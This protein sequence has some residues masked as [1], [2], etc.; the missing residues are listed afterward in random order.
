MCE[1]V[2]VGFG[3]SL[4][5]VRDFLQVFLEFLQ[6]KITSEG[7]YERKPPL[8]ARARGY[9][10][11]AVS[12]L[13]MSRKTAILM[14]GLDVYQSSDSRWFQLQAPPPPSPPDPNNMTRMGRN[15]ENG[16]LIQKSAYLLQVLTVLQTDL[17]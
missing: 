3:E 11:D 5:F 7:S 4:I 15:G 16:F 10:A 9:A 2:P 14:G 1:I 8:A 12:M 17:A 13:A 6:R